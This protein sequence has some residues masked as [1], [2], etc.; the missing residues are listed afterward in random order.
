MAGR[1]IETK[2]ELSHP[3]DGC[4]AESGPAFHCYPG[5]IS[6]ELD[7]KMRIQDLNLHLYR[8]LAL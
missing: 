7:Q 5:L 6:M 8:M 3:P 4:R 2:G 1:V